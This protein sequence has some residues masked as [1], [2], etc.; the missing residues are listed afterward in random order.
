MKRSRCRLVWANSNPDYQVVYRSPCDRVNFIK[1]VDGLR[2]CMSVTDSGSAVLTALSRGRR[3]AV[4][5][6]GTAPC[7]QHGPPELRTVA[8]GRTQPSPALQAIAASTAAS[9]L[10]RPLKVRL[11]SSGKWSAKTD[12][13]REWKIRAGEQPLSGSADFIS[14]S[15][16]TPSSSPHLFSPYAA[17]HT[18]RPERHYA[19]TC[20]P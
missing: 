18:S 10:Q 5:G 16:A 4:H 14:R 11:A 20:W 7:K 1:N 19:T 13:Q 3:T 8:I 9:R 17:E 12:G 2:A 6:P 15:S